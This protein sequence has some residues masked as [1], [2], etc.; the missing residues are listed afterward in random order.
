M[1][2]ADVKTALQKYA[3][4]NDAQ[5]LQRF[6]KTGAGQYGEGDQ[7]IGIR[8]PQTR[9]VC[10]EFK[11]L[12]LHEVQA[13]LD[14]P[15]HEHRLA[16]AILLADK[17]KRAAQ[18]DK[19]AVYDL[20]MK[21][22]YGGR[23]NNWDIVDV[24]CAQVVGA[25]LEKRP[26]DVLRKL[27]RSDE[28]WQKRVAIISTFWYLRTNHDPSTSLDMAEVLVND[29]HDLIQKAVGWTLRE[30]GKSC[31]Q[32]LLTQFLDQ[33]ARTMP[34]TALRYALEKLTPEQKLYYMQLK[35]S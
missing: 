15:I 5:F 35:N 22:V 11:D 2:A 26:R 24:T 4:V 32:D 10:R 30:M 13:L 19:Q 27:A 16:A 20:Y 12:P 23:I 31:G 28:L 25:H 14:S 18:P 21:N 3:N 6:F 29:P 34:R 1:T 9:Q 8:V 7:F 17:Y 33:H